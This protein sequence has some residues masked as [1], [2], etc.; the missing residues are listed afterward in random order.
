M[1]GGT[2][3]KMLLD[4]AALLWLAAGDK[5][6][7]LPARQALGDPDNLAFVS[8]VTAWEIALKA[9]KGKLRLPSPAHA[10]FPAVIKHHRLLVLSIEAEAALAS[11]ALPAIHADPFDRLLIATALAQQMTFLTPDQ[12]IHRYPNLKTLW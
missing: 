12:V 7:S 4:T 6:L 8:A 10:W 11:A 1:A 3:V 2:A 9:A 5:Q